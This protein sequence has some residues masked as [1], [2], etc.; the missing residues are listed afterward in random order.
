MLV[1]VDLD[2][3]GSSV[4]SQAC[5][6]EQAERSGSDDPGLDVLDDRRYARV[7]THGRGNTVDGGIVRA[8]PAV[9]SDQRPSGHVAVGTIR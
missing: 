1:R 7:V 6:Q 4:D 3:D 2:E 9:G 5:G 8:D